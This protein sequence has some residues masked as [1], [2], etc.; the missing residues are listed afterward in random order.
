MS[1]VTVFVHDWKDDDTNSFVFDGDYEVAVQPD[2]IL[3]IL[4]NVPDLLN[5][6]GGTV[7]RIKAVFNH[8]DRVEVD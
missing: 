1:K 2:E 6:G 4:E 7:K 3:I 8:Y 5:K